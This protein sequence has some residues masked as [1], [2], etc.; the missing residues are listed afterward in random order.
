MALPTK[1]LFL[2]L[3]LKENAFMIK[4]FTYL[5]FALTV[6]LSALAQSDAQK[7]SRPDIPG[8]FVVEIG[9]NRDLSGPD[10]FDIGF[11]GSRAANI[12]YQYD[13]RL[14]KSRL[15]LVPAIGVSLERFKF[16]NLATMGFDSDDS[17]RL[18][19]PTEAGYTRVK[20]SQLIT[21][22][23]ELPIELRYSSNP[24]DP[25]RSFKAGVGFRIGYLY[26][27]FNKVK[28]TQ[29]GETKKIKDKQNFNLNDFRYGVFGR[30][31][32]GNFSVVGYY[33]L[34]NLFKDGKGPGVTGGPSGVV[35]DF[36][37]FTV[38]VSLSS[39]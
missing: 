39:F 24:E 25:A 17:L 23:V 28:F 33:N 9:V 20:K 27:S 31:G 30:V 6:S 16:R 14:F 10:N 8:T 7:T 2:G 36:N 38:G 35:T 4:K 32:L 3:V 18:L 1:R 15:S 37:T 19:S 34:T 11:W 13:I 12:Y 29:D 21:N 5:A 26:D 22:Y